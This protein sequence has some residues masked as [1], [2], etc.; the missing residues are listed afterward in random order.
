IGQVSALGYLYFLM[1]ATRK[2]HSAQP[3]QLTTLAARQL[4]QRDLKN[5]LGAFVTMNTYAPLYYAS[6]WLILRMMLKFSLKQKRKWMLWLHL[7]RD[8]AVLHGR[9]VAGV[10]DKGRTWYK[11][12]DG[13][14][15]ASSLSPI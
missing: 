2:T 1:S 4:P 9:P 3:N 11:M 15:G 10:W 6:E 5:I 12:V 7:R 13:C 14:L 8:G